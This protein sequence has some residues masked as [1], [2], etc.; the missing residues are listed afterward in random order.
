MLRR[1]QSTLLRV[2]GGHPAGGNP[3][4]MI[5]FFTDVWDQEVFRVETK[6]KGTDIILNPYVS[7]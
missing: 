1:Q 5:D 4:G 7:T 3:I 2:A 6:N